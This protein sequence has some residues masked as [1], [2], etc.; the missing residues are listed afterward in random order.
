MKK[1]HYVFCYGTLRKHQPN[2]PL[3]K[4]AKCIAGQSWTAGRLYDT[5][6]GYPVTVS[7]STENV[8]GELYRI[9]EDGLRYLDRL[10][11]YNGVDAHD[12]LFERITQPVMTGGGQYKA[13]V[14]IEGKNKNMRKRYIHDGDW[15]VYRL[16]QEMEKLHYFAYGSCMDDAR[17]KSAGVQSYFQN[18]I[19]CGKLSGYSLKFT[20]KADDG[21]G[22]ADI[23]E[24]G[25]N[26]EGKVYE[27][28]SEALKY[29]YR[30]EGVNA[31]CY[32][33]AF[34]DVTV[35]G[36]LF[37]DVLTF[38]VIDKQPEIAPPKSYAEEILCGAAGCLSEEYISKLKDQLDALVRPKAI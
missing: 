19:G 24:D 7:D 35:E 27:I 37:K 21:C 15:K 25:G 8:Y 2:H 28:E 13:V 16:T 11:G 23:V 29:L 4:G 36:K 26:V 3:L 32:R 22:R 9:S 30:R 12:N 34:V 10:E 31:G 6:Y 18:V 20:R 14:Y 17:F 33:P 1:S 38:V 5:G